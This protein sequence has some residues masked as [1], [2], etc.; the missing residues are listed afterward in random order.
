MLHLAVSLGDAFD[1]LSEGHLLAAV[2]VLAD[3]RN[4]AALGAIVGSC[5]RWHGIRAAMPL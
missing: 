5:R 1:K 2:A 4:L 3:R